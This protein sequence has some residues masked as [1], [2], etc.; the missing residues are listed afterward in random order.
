MCGGPRDD[1]FAVFRARSLASVDLMNKS[2]P[3]VV[4]ELVNALLQTHTEYR[5][6]NPEWNKIFTFYVLDFRLLYV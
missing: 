1:F 5:T 6:I 2:N 3:F 4:V